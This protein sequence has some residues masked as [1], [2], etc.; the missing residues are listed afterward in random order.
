MDI[1]AIGKNIPKY[2]KIKFKDSKLL[3]KDEN[4]KKL[5]VTKKAVKK[6]IKYTSNIFFLKTFLTS[7]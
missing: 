4:A 2:C 1:P 3:A 7:F 6:L 5:K